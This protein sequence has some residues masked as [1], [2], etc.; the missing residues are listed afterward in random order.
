MEIK[1]TPA[2]EDTLP[3][4]DL[5]DAFGS[6]EIAAAFDVM[7]SNEIVHLLS[8]Q[9]Y[10]SPL[11]AI[12]EIVVNAYD[13]DAAECRIGLLLG[14]A[15][16]PAADAAGSVTRSRSDPIGR[17]ATGGAPS[18]LIAIYDDGEGMDLG[19][20]KSLWMVG[21]SPKRNLTTGT[22]RF[23]RRAV[24][25]FGIG[26]LATYSVAN[27][28]TYVTA[29]SAGVYHV[30]CDFK[31]FAPQAGGSKPVHLEVR[32]VTNLPG[33]LARKDMSAVLAKLDLRAAAL[34]DGSTP[35]WTL[36]LLDDLKPKAREL[37]IGRLGWVLRTAM[38]LRS[39]FAVFLD[40]Q[41]QL[42]SKESVAEIVRF[43][44]GALNDERIAALNKEHGTQLAR[45]G[46]HLIEPTLFPSGIKG[47]AY[48]TEGSLIGKSDTLMG[49]SF[50]FFVRVRGRV[51]NLDDPLFHNTPIS[52]GTFNR[53][54]ADLEIDDL[55]EDVTAPREGVGLGRRRDVAAAIAREI[56]L[57]ARNLY[58]DW[59]A[60][61][62][63][64]KLTPEET[65]VYVAEHLVERPMA[66]ALA[67]H[68]T[69]RGTGPDVDGNWLYLEDVAPADMT[70]V[71]EQL[72]Q[73]RTRYNFQTVALG[74]EARLA[75]FNPAKSLFTINDDHQ[76]VQ[77][78]KDDPRSKELLDLLV[79][80]EVMLEVYMVESGLDRF[81]IGEVLNRRDTLLRSL[82]E[83][84][85]YSREAVVDMLQRN[86]DNAIG[87]EL[88]LIAAVRSLGFQ[89][90]H[91]GGGG[92]PDGIARFLDTQMN[93]TTITL[94]AKASQGTPALS[95]LD[96]G[97][98]EEH[99]RDSGAAGCLLVAPAYPGQSDP[100]G[101]VS[102][103]AL[104]GG[105]SCWTVDQL[106]RVVQAAEQLEITTKQIAAIVTTKFA[107][108]HVAAAIDE[109]LGSG[110]NMT[111]LYGA[112]MEV[113]RQMFA[114]RSQRGDAREIGAITALLAQDSRF[115]DITKDQV[116]RALVHLASQS[117]GGMVIREDIIVFLTDFEEVTRRVASLT[118]ELG[119][120]RSLGTFRS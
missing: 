1:M 93:E 92:Q 87:L 104:S 33:L 25:K 16:L 46:N 6:G 65:R 41:E 29:T 54:R 96:F 102:S 56:G 61:Q 5:G 59:T 74:R 35:T 116:R 32:A 50:G 40:G 97:G 37:K 34:T 58:D 103:R 43:N 36:C 94:E 62:A 15:R 24:G 49:R 14:D 28:I 26:K 88:A 114:R 53:F 71:I 84:R 101:A 17:A 45:S 98:L 9:L 23:G 30:M 22:K 90:K 118:G 2:L 67:I 117:R 82:A 100:V 79:A 27:R 18:G 111:A 80:A 13:A 89:V 106:A 113:L 81:I 108:I 70:S 75:R 39:G 110:P 8:E 38:P 95:N 3:S 48:V 76:L 72:Y 60:K 73:K 47:D 44:T 10:T 112:S 78:F 69:T 119:G 55:H 4:T 105:I 20:L 99:K 68:G 21:D 107:P 109:L 115:S 42:S 77:A 31:R 57:Q 64:Q 19:G 66:D 12:E 83:D 52:H 91:V 11:K 63:D 7:L 120:P 51:V 85:V 86:P